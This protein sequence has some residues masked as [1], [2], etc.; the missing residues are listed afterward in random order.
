MAGKVSEVETRPWR[1]QQEMAQQNRLADPEVLEP[2][3]LE[4]ERVLGQDV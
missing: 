2:S 3:Q 4:S 1:K